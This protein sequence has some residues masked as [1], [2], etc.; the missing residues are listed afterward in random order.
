MANFNFNKV[1]LGGRLTSDVELKQTPAGVS[2]C[3]FGIAV[4]R[5]YQSG[6]QQ[7]ADFFNVTAWRAT[8]EFVSKYFHKGSSIFIM[9]EIQPRSWTDINNVTHKTVDIIAQEVQFVDSKNDSYSEVNTGGY[10][11]PAYTA[12]NEARF[13]EIKSDDDLPF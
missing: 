12:P 13:E 10:V 8:A 9:G 7:K 5:Q 3:S 6:G 4:N 1:I 11:P 2:V